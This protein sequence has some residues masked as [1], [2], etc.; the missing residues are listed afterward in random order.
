MH[1]PAGAPLFCSPFPD[2][3]RASQAQLPGCSACSHRADNG[4]DNGALA[5]HRL[6]ALRFVDERDAARHV[7]ALLQRGA[8]ASAACCTAGRVLPLHAAA[9]ANNTALVRALLL[10]SRRHLDSCSA[11]GSALHLAVEYRAAEAMAALLLEG[12]D[13]N[14]RRPGD[15][16]TPLHVAAAAG[17]AAAVQLLLNHGADAGKATPKGEAPLHLA[18]AAASVGPAQQASVILALARQQPALLSQQPNCAL[19][20][21]LHI[22]ARRGRVAALQAL[23]EH[24]PPLIPTAA[25]QECDGSGCTPLTA[26]CAAGQITAAE[27]L[28]CR[29]QP[30]G[31]SQL[32][33]ALLAAST[34]GHTGIVRLLLLVKG[35]ASSGSNSSRS[36]GSPH[37]GP[38]SSMPWQQLPPGRHPLLAAIRQGHR[39]VVQ[40]LLAAGVPVP[41]DGV[42]DAVQ[43]GSR[44]VLGVLLA[45][46]PKS[47]AGEGQ[48]QQEVWVWVWFSGLPRAV[49]QVCH[50][51]AA[52][53]RGEVYAAASDPLHKLCCSLAVLCSY[54]FPVSPCCCCCLTTADLQLS[55][56]RA[57][58]IYQHALQRGR[59]PLLAQLLTWGLDPNGAS[60]DGS[61]IGSD[62]SLVRAPL[63]QALEALNHQAVRQLLQHGADPNPSTQQLLQRWGQDGGGGQLPPLPLPAWP[64]HTAALLLDLEGVELLL[65]AGADPRRKDLLGYS[66]L[67]NVLEMC[68]SWSKVSG[69]VGRWAHAQMVA[70][71][72]AALVPTPLRQ[73]QAVARANV[74]HICMQPSYHHKLGMSV[75]T[76]K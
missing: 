18:A 39:A 44:P 71:G 51:S 38:A 60:C 49:P 74:W 4:A 73:A 15:G 22:L 28:L 17:D 24:Q 43:A 54:L 69:W 55:G 75:G 35:P 68:C 52:D 14:V 29:Q 26:A 9:R 76:S 42:L 40:A 67:D 37:Y 12:A 32:L 13:A 50:A 63:A 23:L 56:G 46:L 16:C 5:L 1:P 62:S 66:A 10:H 48:V 64:L 59:E 61:T 27:L 21:P 36:V 45:A 7:T 58:R 8:S 11:S 33:D 65:A 70:Y 25:L 53:R 6:A 41:A 20:T 19:G 47:D 57:H 31:Q 3:D 30:L 72:G 2:N 34:W